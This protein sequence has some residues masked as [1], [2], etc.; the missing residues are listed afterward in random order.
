MDKS[1]KYSSDP[2][3]NTFISLTVGF[4]IRIPNSDPVNL[5][6]S[7]SYSGYNQKLTLAG[8]IPQAFHPFGLKWLTMA[9]WRGEVVVDMNKKALDYFRLRGI[10]AISAGGNY[11]SASI[12]G[13][14]DG[15]GAF[16]IAVRDVDP[17]AWG[18]S[19]IS[20]ARSVLSSSGSSGNYDSLLNT[21]G[22]SAQGKGFKLDIIISTKNY[23]D[24]VYQQQMSKGLTVLGKVPLPNGSL[25]DTMSMFGSSLTNSMFTMGVVLPV[26]GGSEIQ[27]WF[28]TPGARITN[29][30]YMMG[31]RF[32]L[33]YSGPT[34]IQ[35]GLEGGL[36]ITPKNNQPLTFQAGFAITFPS[37]TME[38]YAYMVGFWEN[39]FGLKGFNIGNAALQIG[40]NTAMCP[41]GCISKFG[42]YGEL[43]WFIKSQNKLVTF[44]LGGAIDVVSGSIFFRTALSTNKAGAYALSTYDLVDIYRRVSGRQISDALIPN[45]G[46]YYFEFAFATYSGSLGPISFSPGF[47]VSG[48]VYL[49]GLEVELMVKAV[50]DPFDFAFDFSLNAEVWCAKVREF[51]SYIVPSFLRWFFDICVERVSLTGFSLENIKRGIWPRLQIT[52]RIFGFT[53]TLD[54][55]FDIFSIFK[56]FGSFFL[57]MIRYLFI[58]IGSFI[59]IFF[60]YYIV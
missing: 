17:I 53:K 22:G 43:Q 60:S 42:L 48:K 38:F 31:M 35:L 10:V 40:F 56:S 4:N 2:N 34:N 8:E 29:T 13:Q 33:K 58:F 32:Y 18:N 9:N 46:I 14:V 23:F 44:A 49:L 36:R 21:G 51:I 25:K 37:T 52:L 54:F 26:A 41:V 12:D 57:S 55:K 24:D 1:G 47:L 39:A 30:V 27:I 3:Q 16:Y 20:V 19:I 7:G 50:T 28:T 15:T 11:A 5:I 45:A 59:I 6:V